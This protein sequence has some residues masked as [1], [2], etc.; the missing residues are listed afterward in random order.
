MYRSPEVL[1]IHVCMYLAI[2][3]KYLLFHDNDINKII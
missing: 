3:G 2:L 1:F